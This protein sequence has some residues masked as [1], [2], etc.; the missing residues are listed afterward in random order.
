MIEYSSNP[1]EIRLSAAVSTATLS[2]PANIEFDLPVVRISSQR[3]G[4][5]EPCKAVI[6]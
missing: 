6:T 2:L 5:E 4:P 3:N 1:V